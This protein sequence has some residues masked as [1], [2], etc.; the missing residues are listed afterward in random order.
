M[1]IL[2]CLQPLIFSLALFYLREIELLVLRMFVGPE[3]VK[4]LGAVVSGLKSSGR[5]S[6][7]GKQAIQLALIPYHHMTW[8]VVLGGNTPQ[9]WCRRHGLLSRSTAGGGY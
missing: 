1:Y 3:V 4:L 2:F 8:R 7:L 9:L 5:M 6:A